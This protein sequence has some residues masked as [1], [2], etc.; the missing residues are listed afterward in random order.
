MAFKYVIMIF[1]NP[2]EIFSVTINWALKQKAIA[3]VIFKFSCVVCVGKKKEIYDSPF[4]CL[5]RTI[6]LAFFEFVFSDFSGFST[7]LT[8]SFFLAFFICDFS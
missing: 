7:D 5:S 3:D 1:L 8:F 6:Y 4:P 2:E